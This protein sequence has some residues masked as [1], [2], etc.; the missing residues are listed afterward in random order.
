MACSAVS[1]SLAPKLS[2]WEEFYVIA[3]IYLNLKLYWFHKN[4][5]YHVRKLHRTPG[6]HEPPHQ[7]PRAQGPTTSPPQVGPCPP[8]GAPAQHKDANHLCLCLCRHPHFAATDSRLH[9]GQGLPSCVKSLAV[10][11][12]G[13]QG[14]SRGG[15]RRF[16]RPGWAF[17]G[18]CLGVLC[19]SRVSRCKPEEGRGVEFC[20]DTSPIAQGPLC[21]PPRAVCLLTWKAAAAQSHPRPQCCI[22]GSW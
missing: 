16:L 21:R 4:A 15:L 22:P 19:G 20:G 7:L 14:S 1:T 12:A 2:S 9:H 3:S 10:R 18:G 17:P 13:R 6:A 11:L 5:V 8:E